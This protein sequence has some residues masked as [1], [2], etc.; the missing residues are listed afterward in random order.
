MIDLKE[1]V[2][3]FPVE[4][5]SDEF[6]ETE[7]NEIFLSENLTDGSSRRMCRGLIVKPLLK[8]HV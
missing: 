4:K 2:S 8:K 6:C 7:L 3:V 5:A 1:Y